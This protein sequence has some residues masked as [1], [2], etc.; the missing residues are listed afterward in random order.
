MVNTVL[1]LFHLVDTFDINMIY[2]AILILAS[3]SSLVNTFD[4]NMIYND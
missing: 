4:I 2:N 1:L 3:V